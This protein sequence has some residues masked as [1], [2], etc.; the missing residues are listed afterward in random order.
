MRHVVVKSH[1]FPQFVHLNRERGK[2]AAVPV[3][4]VGTGERGEVVAVKRAW[5]SGERWGGGSQSQ[6]VGNPSESRRRQLLTT[7]THNRHLV[8]GPGEAEG[9]G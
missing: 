3:L 9:L 6:W 5:H 8:E 7:L 1:L 4:A 2:V